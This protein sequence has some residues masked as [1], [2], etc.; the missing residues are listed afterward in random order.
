MRNRDINE[1]N[2]SFSDTNKTKNDIFFRPAIKI[3]I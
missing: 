1:G 2:V 3:Y